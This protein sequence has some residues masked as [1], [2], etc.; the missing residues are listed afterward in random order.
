M[1]SPEQLSPAALLQRAKVNLSKGNFHAAKR[2]FESVLRMVPGHAESHM[3]LSRIAYEDCEQDTCLT[4][5]ENAIQGAPQALPLRL[6]IAERYRH[7]GMTEKALTAFDAAAKIAPKEVKP[8]AERA[9]YL[10]TLGRFKEA[11]EAFRKL[12]KKHPEETELYRIYLG[13]KKVKSGDPM[14]RQMAK[15]WNDPRLN[16]HGKMQLGF[17][18]AKANEDLGETQKV[19]ALLKRANDAQQRLAPSTSEISPA[20][21]W[22]IAKSAQ[23]GANF[24]PVTSEP[25]IRPVFVT[26]M[27]RSGTTLV[28]QIIASHSSATAGGELAHIVKTAWGKFVSHNRMTPL[29]EIPETDLIAW[30]DRYIQLVMRDTQATSGVVTD[31]SILTQM[32]FGMVHRAIPN[33]RIIVVNRD[34]RDIALSIFKNQFK[35]GTHRYANALEDIAEAIK[36]FREAVAFWKDAMPGVIHEVRYED[37]VTD[38]E[39]QARALIEAAGLDWEDQ[40]LDFHNS[41]A[42]VKTL[43]LAQVRQPIHSGRRAAWKKYETEMQPFIEAWG[44]TPWD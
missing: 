10:Q 8:K 21:N 5:L 18:L 29:H 30:R 15:L 3:H 40:C 38:P 34:P 13:T 27:P 37:L 31:K 9:Q 44:D 36:L 33:A 11:D 35:L 26:G 39:P 22:Q 23:M 41:K 4:H 7:F 2:D 32:I 25:K 17:A 43:S 19:F 24:D 6:A 42:E 1:L 28:E 14:L 20:V 12:I 16:D